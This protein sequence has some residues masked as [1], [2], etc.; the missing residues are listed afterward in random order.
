MELENIGRYERHGEGRPVLILS[1]PQ[2]DPAWWAEPYVAALV[3]SGYEVI[4]FVHTGA[5]FT[6]EAVVIDIATFLEYLDCDPVRLLGWSQGAAIAQEV[7]LR[8]PDRVHAAVLIAGYGRQNS[9]DRLLQQA[10]AVLA[11]SGDRHE[12]VRMA[13]QFLTAYPPSLLGEDNFVQAHL[14][15]I[16]QSSA[17]PQTG[18]HS[19][20]RSAAFINGY[21]DR[22]TA[23]AEVRAPCLS[24][25]FEL[26]ADTFVARAREVAEA[27][28][29]CQYLE[30]AGAGH[31]TPVTHPHLVIEPVL[32]FF[33]DIAVSR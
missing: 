13:L 19:R 25:G 21:Q 10:W 28:P 3:A 30:I 23:L 9:F 26:D 12:P 17:N 4:T 1:N 33:H 32:T 27:I 22:L 2:A 5:S 16:R 14:D 18:A 7:A 29:D 6:P 24:I 15:G 20:A 31:L 11:D 8:C